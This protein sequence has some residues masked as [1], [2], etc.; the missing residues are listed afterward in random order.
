M[1]KEILI[2]TTAPKAIGPYS[3]ALK[4]G[5]LVFASGQLPADPATGELVEGNIEVQ[6]QRAL[7][8]LRLVL[9]PFGIGLEHIVKV[10]IFLK[11]MNNFSRVNEI[12]GQYFSSD[13]PARSCIEVA[14]LPKDAQ[15]EVEAIAYC[16]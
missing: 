16:D 1:K 8:N 15:I 5:N 7:D 13:F 3:P 2:N 11:D 4:I 12:Y 14:R 10:T 9:Q 6:A